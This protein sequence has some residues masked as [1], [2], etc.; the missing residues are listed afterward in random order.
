LTLS[1]DVCHSL[2]CLNSH[3]AKDGEDGKAGEDASDKGEQ[4]YKY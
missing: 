3:E 2:A 4:W 1:D